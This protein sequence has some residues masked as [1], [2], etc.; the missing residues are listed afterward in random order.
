MGVISRRIFPACAN[1][2]VCCP[3]LRSRSR[4]PVKR[5]KKLLAEIFPRSL[6]G[7]PNE[8]KITKLCEYA[9]KNSFRIPK[10]AKYLEE[11]CYKELRSEHIKFLNIVAETYN[12]L[13]CLCRNQMACFAV[14]LL[15]VATELLENSKQDATRILGCQ[16]LTR[17]IYSQVDGI[18]AH[19]IEKFVERVC[20][21]ACENGEEHQK[22]CLRASSL[23][24]LS[25]MVWFM[26]E[27]SH[28]FADF[29][30]IVH[31]TLENYEPDSSNEDYDNRGVLHHNWVAEVIRC[32]GRGSA[33]VGSDASSCTMV[34]SHPDKKDPSRL[35]R[36]EIETPKVWAQICVQRM[37]ELAKE[38]TTM[39]RVLDPMFVYFDTGHHWSSRQGLALVVLSD[40]TYFVADLAGQQL[41][42]ASVIRHMDHKNIGHDPELKSHVI[43]VATALAREIRSASVLADFAFVTDLCR[44]LRKSFQATAGAV[45]DHEMSLNVSLQN[46]IEDCLLEIAKGIGD[47]R[48]L[49]DMMAITLEKLPSA[50]AVAR[51]TIASLVVLAHTISSASISLQSQQVFPEALLIQLL[52]VMLH[53]DVEARIGAH[54]IFSVLLIPNSNNLR[55]EVGLLRSGYFRE[56]R[57]HSDTSS[58]FASITALLEKLRREKDGKNTDKHGSNSSD[59]TKEK[60][61][62][63]EDRKHGRALKNSP[64]YCKISSIIER[65]AGSTSMDEIELCFMK[66]TE[67]Q[68]AQL[69]SAFWMQAILPDNLPSN[70]EAISH[71]FSLTLIYSRLKNFNDNLVV[72]FF[73]LPLSLKNKSLDLNNGLLLPSC[74]RSVLVLATAMMMFAA[75]IYHIPGLIELLKSFVQHDADP[76]LGISDDLQVYVKPQVDLRKYGCA[77]DNQVATS[78]L[79][80]LKD[81][82]H[83]SNKVILDMIVQSVLSITKL[84]ADDLF[85]QLREPFTPDDTFMFGPKSILEMDQIQASAH[86]KES[87]SL[88]ED[89]PSNAVIEDDAMSQ[90][91]VADISRFIPKVPPSP[92]MSHIISIGQLLE[93]ALEVAGHVAGTSVSTSPLPYSTM[94]SQCEA[95][96]S[97]TRK[98]LST[99]LT[100][101]NQYNRAADKISPTFHADAQSE[102]TKITSDDARVPSAAL[103]SDPWMALRLP[104]ASPFDNFLRAAGC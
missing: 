59:D 80:Y 34:R 83:E 9:A 49:C 67:D 76:Y 104:P 94:A 40:M 41:I 69:L 87:L 18:Y 74:R 89:F 71:S 20:K 28:V 70:I 66:F 4:H 88:D 97:G 14:S 62:F 53:P 60:D 11:R 5:Y 78:Y 13:L 39:R 96:G 44:H 57:W 25:A 48:P 84:G 91:S 21:L 58:A 51:A 30:K 68:I 86:S 79:S 35:T 63:N 93:S 12:K 64:N 7:P 102:F 103:V 45:G 100:H 3:A 98:K 32:E 8:R 81:K 17:F 16:T 95:L 6:D 33:G 38:S 61:N 85:S 26:S 47:A 54:Q 101:E 23:Q 92:S 22:R 15:N 24:C 36:E 50:G 27:F 1:M 19:N 55:H 42:L 90:S 52:K 31:A 82:F 29:D 56:P 99:W 10:I 77:V 73:Q 65:K 75:K 37:I 72:R 2:C 43:H 46:S